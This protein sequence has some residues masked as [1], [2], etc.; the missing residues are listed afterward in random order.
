MVLALLRFKWILVFVLAGITVLGLFVR[1]A[2]SGMLCARTKECRPLLDNT[3]GEFLGSQALMQKDIEFIRNNPD[4][5]YS[6]IQIHKDRLVRSA[7]ISLF[8]IYLVFVVINLITGIF[9]SKEQKNIGIY[10]MEI[11]FALIIIYL[12]TILYLGFMYGQWNFVP[13]FGFFDPTNGL[14]FNLD[15]L[16]E[17][18]GT[19]NDPFIDAIDALNNTV[20][21]VTNSLN[22]V[23]VV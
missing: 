19:Y 7:V 11:F 23:T 4:A 13:F 8:M 12:S 1:I 18:I 5:D 10:A 9:I 6:I 21:N 22:N 15:V 16:I 3:V 20:G 17:S 2:D 14:F